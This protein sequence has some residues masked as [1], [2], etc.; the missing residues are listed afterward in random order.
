MPPA[1]GE[2]RPIW[3]HRLRRFLFGPPR[4][5]ADRSLFHRLSLV[6]LLAWVGLGA[7]GLSSS[8]YGPEE[9]FR[10]LGEHTYLAVGLA[11]LMAVT[12]LVI[13]AAYGR[14][15]EEFPHGG[16]GYVVATKLLGK[17]SGLI[18]G[19]ALLVDYVL[20]ITISI[21]AAGDAIFSLLP[22]ELHAWKVP[23]EVFLLLALTVLNSRGARE[24]ILV[25]AP[26]FLLFALTHL[27]LI[28]GGLFT[29][30]PQFSTSAR[31]VGE[32]FGHGWAT[33]G[34]GGLLM[35]FVHAYSLGGGTY[36]GIEAVS[37]GLAIM[38][39]PKVQTARRTMVYM[40]TSLA[41][42]AAGLLVCYLLW[43]L[44]PA[45]GKTMNAVLAERVAAG[46][47]GGRTFVILALV[48]EG[49]LLVVAS[50]AGFMDGP[51]VL[52]NLAVD[53]WMPRRFATLSDR[54][55]TLNGILLMGGASLLALLTTR[56]DVRQL[57]VLYSINVFLT[58]SLSLFAMMRAWFR[59][60]KRRA[61][62][63]R[64]TLLFTSGFV[65]CATI[66]SVTVIEKFRSGGW[67]TLVVTGGVVLLCSIIRRHYDLVAAK[68]SQLAREVPVSLDP[69]P[70]APPP[71]DP[72]KPT[73]VIL[74]A[75]YG[76]LGVHTVM[77]IIHSFPGW[78]RNFLFV[79]VGVIDSGV[80]KGG[81]ELEALRAATEAN[82]QKYVRL[83]NGMGLAAAGRSAIGTDAV[84]ESEK[85][86]LSIVEEF[87]QS[88]FFAGQIIFHRERWYDRLLHNQTAFA[89]QKRL[90]WQGKTM[91]I[92]PAVVR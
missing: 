35:L 79:S 66:L 27:L 40:A 23:V 53:S 28:G 61:H 22:P 6:P 19:S 81:D 10:T 41:F 21:A 15:I 76:G 29:R 91:V 38:R 50:Q 5:L 2:E 64:R 80:F 32:G 24:S 45:E 26:V 18:S 63:K 1:A 55:T 77:K 83:A 52:A 70:S 33:L 31:S 92:L 68:F 49:A 51:R 60:R 75:G 11:V 67:L 43:N 37:N 73:A 9:A 78:Y 42:T 85:L 25:L 39:E 8:A 90:Q 14:I 30:A 44:A 4:D 58:F 62:W 36:T 82:L 74:V 57:V 88:V 87:P 46:W 72:A 86:C 13:S 69:S 7:D 20:T 56:G 17:R 48:S 47:P 3:S 84:D 65:L 59:S 71:L 34:L 16:G 54:L 89:I 12:V